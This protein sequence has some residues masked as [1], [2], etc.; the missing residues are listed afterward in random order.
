MSHSESDCFHCGLPVPEGLECGVK[1]MGET[2]SMCCPGCEAVANAIVAGGLESFYLQRTESTTPT[3][4]IPSA[5]QQTEIYDNAQLQQSF[6]SAEGEIKEASLILEGIVCAACVWLNERHVSGLS[7][8]ISF[9][10]NYSNHRARL[11]WDDSQIHLSD[12]LNAIAAIGYQAHPFDPGRQEALQKKERSIFLR[13]LALAG[14]SMMQVMMIA[15]G[16][17]SGDYYGMDAELKYFLRWVSLVMTLP[18][19]FYSALPFFTGAWRDLKRRQ[20]GMDV[21]VALAIGGAFL[22]SLWSTVSG[23]GEVYYDSVVMFTF[24]LLAGRFLEMLARH[25]AG[26]ITEALVRLTPATAVRLD[27]AG[28]ESLIPVVDLSVDDRVIIKPGEVVPADGRVLEGISSV[29]ESLLSGESLPRDRRVGDRLTGGTLNIESPLLMQVE[30]IGEET[31]LSSVIRLLDR[32]QAEKPQL[33]RLADR[34]AAWFVSVLL[35]LASMVAFWWWQHAPADAFW[36]TFSVLVVSCPCALS[37]AT[38]AALTAAT[39]GLTQ[40]GLLTTRGH[41]LETLA[42]ATHI[43]FDKTGTLTR[44]ELQLHEVRLFA[45]QDKTECLQLAAALEARSEHP[46]AKILCHSV[47]H[48]LQVQQLRSVPGEGIEGLIEGRRYRIGR[49]SFVLQGLKHDFSMPENLL[50]TP[51]L[52]AN[53]ER[54]L[55]LFVLQDQLRP[56]AKQSI[57]R[58]RELGLQVSLL[59]GD[60]PKLVRQVADELGV[61]EAH[62]GLLPEDKLAHIQALQQQGAVVAMVGDGVN[63]APVLAAAQVS[64][65][66]GGGTQLAHASA[67]MV[68]LSENLLH[69]SEGVKMAR[70]T[71]NVIRQNLAWA[72]LYNLVALPL[73]AMGLVAPWMAAIGMSASSLLVVVNALR[74]RVVKAIS[75]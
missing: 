56:E 6:V 14:F 45:E 42:Q 11:R 2:R 71:L 5:L 57:E 65:A 17:Y 50:G 30:K 49:A 51:V 21:P 32:A 58:L 7:G 70:R 23:E 61:M 39:G 13:R 22:V 28:V 72:L 68:L 44:G 33:A 15:V 31:M 59:S 26:R 40:L 54:L 19:V 73:A 41:A 29:D 53:E 24:F 8:V 27:A 35:L 18:V 10:I 63:D 3:E 64:L 66:M 55:A 75:T 25:K 16:L 52:L 48:S 4:L 9:Q 36:V 67:D 12:V 47:E 38:P 62:G 37:L 1:I 69:L 60:E 46:L 74:L 34:V 20:L 43:V